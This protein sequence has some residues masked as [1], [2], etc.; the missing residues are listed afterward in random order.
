MSKDLVLV[1]SGGGHLQQ[2]RLLV[3][4]LPI[5]GH[6]RWITFDTP[7]SRSLLDGEDVTHVPYMGPRDYRGLAANLR[8]ASKIGTKRTTAAVVSTGAGL[9]LAYLPLSSARRIPTY[10]IESA[11]RVHGPSTTGR[12]LATIPTIHVRTQH[13]RWAGRRWKY[14]GSVF[15]GFQAIAA[16]PGAG[17]EQL[18]K[19]VVSLGTIRGYSFRRLVDRLLTIIDPDVEVIWQVGSTDV[20]D[21][22]IDARTEIPT[23]ELI[24]EIKSADALVAHAGTGIALTAFLAGVSP[25]LVPREAAHDEHVD[26]HQLQTAELLGN[27]GLAVFR[28]VD[29]L[30]PNDLLLPQAKAITQRYESSELVLA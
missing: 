7:Q 20:S 13:E 19:V 6:R 23:S 3:E 14:G 12:L 27:A 9:A 26:D 11:T 4:R 29:E 16:P 25:V 2:L 17:S 5:D 30:M 24:D 8:L 1:A 22:P 21:L 15:E 10:F 28:R 18:R